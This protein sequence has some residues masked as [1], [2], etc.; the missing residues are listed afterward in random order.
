[1]NERIGYTVLGAVLVVGALYL[2]GAWSEWKARQPALTPSRV[3][4][5][6]PGPLP[7]VQL[8]R[9]LAGL[10]PLRDSRTVGVTAYQ[11]APTFRPLR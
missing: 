7:T 11:P 1:M 2:Y 5:V 9:A 8:G 6:T 3:A 4:P 10:A